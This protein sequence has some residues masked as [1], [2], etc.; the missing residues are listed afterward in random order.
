[1]RLLT[2]AALLLGANCTPYHLTAPDPPPIDALAEPPYGMGQICVL[3][4]HSLGALITF[5]VRDNDQLVGATRGPSY[6]C[7]FVLPG[8]HHVTS[9]SGTIAAVD[10]A[11]A[12]GSRHYLHQVVRIG[13]DELTPIDEQQAAQQLVRCEYRLLVDPPPG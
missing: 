11:V 4:P 10:L 1:M 12:P 8:S 7:Y 3:R 2:L 13:P 5:V 9:D 6:F